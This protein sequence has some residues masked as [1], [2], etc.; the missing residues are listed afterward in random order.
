ML[1]Q[2]KP[3][4][5]APEPTP[6]SRDIHN[7]RKVRD[8]LLTK[9]LS[10]MIVTGIPAH[11]RASSG[12][13]PVGRSRERLPAALACTQPRGRCR[14]MPRRQVPRW[15]AERRDVPIARDVR[16][17]AS[18][19]ACL[20]S[21]QG[22]LAS[23]PRLPALRSPFAWRRGSRKTDYGAAG[24]AKQTAGEAMTMLAIATPILLENAFSLHL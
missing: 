10:R 20:A 11:R 7:G 22:C 21:A 2:R 4:N 16:R 24:A 8:G 19:S 17:P 3:P 14:Q 9:I 6:I 23:T 15:S 5:G 18:V 13:S 12:D 1:R